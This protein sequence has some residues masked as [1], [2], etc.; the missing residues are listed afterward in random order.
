MRRIIAI[1]L[2]LG[3]AGAATAGDVALE[4]SWTLHGFDAPESVALASGGGSLYVSNVNGE[5]D[6]VDGNGYISLVSTDG[7]ILRKKWATGLNAPKGVVVKGERLFVADITRVVEID[8]KTGATV[9]TH[10]VPGAKFLNDTALAP[11]GRILASDSDAGRIYALDG[12]VATIL[13]EDARLAEVN[14]LL[15]ENAWLVIVTMKGLLLAMDWKT[16]AL[17]QIGS[18]F[19]NGDGVAALGDGRFLVSEWP[20]QLWAVNADGT[21]TTLVDSRAQGSYINDFVL[22]GERLYVPHWKPGS[23]SLYRVKR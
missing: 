13:L 23:L 7:K 14:G 16:K 15:P 10:V 22:D 18:G 6:A 9:A 2:A 20:G 8:V 12:D 19:G 5:A 17:T 4:T 3:S 1:F 11:D 21:K